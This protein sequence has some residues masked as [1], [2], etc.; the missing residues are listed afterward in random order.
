MKNLQRNVR[1]P[2]GGIDGDSR[3]ME[4]VSAITL[5]FAALRGDI[6]EIR[7]FAARMF[8]S[9]M[10]V[11]TSSAYPPGYGRTRVFRRRAHIP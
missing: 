1:A 5:L 4:D 8:G 2:G 9:A 3:P 10:G 7:H 6:N 11:T